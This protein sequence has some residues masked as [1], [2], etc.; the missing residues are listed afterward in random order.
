M[1]SDNAAYHLLQK[2]GLTYL[3][4]SHLGKRPNLRHGF[5][6]RLGG[7]SEGI[8]ASLNLAFNRE[9][10]AENVYENFRRFCN[11]LEI[12]CD[13]LVFTDQKHEDKIRTVSAKDKG[14]GII[15]PRDYQGIDALVT[16]VPGIPLAAFFADCVPLFFFD[17]V[18]K[19]IGVAHAGWRGTLLKIGAKTVKSLSQQY[20]SNPQDILAGI[21]PSIGPCCYEV[22]SDVADQFASAGFTQYG[23]LRQ[24]EKGLFLLDL[25]RA[26]QQ[27]LLEAGLREENIA[28][29]DICTKCHKEIFFSHR[30]HEGKRGAMAAIIALIK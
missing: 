9:D 1:T 7:I 19:A 20:G 23:C 12:D 15:R 29:A 11:A 24:K 14:K 3:S 22:G 18:R 21:G 8:F 16:N 4:F 2:D 25:Q 10:K 26:N 6:T 28:I 13:D 30:G 5:S 17:P 27:I